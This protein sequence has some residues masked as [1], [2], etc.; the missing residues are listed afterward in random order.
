MTALKYRDAV[1]I[2]T[3]QPLV[4]QTGPT[5]QDDNARPH[6]ARIVT[7]YVQQQGLQTLP[8]PAR[9][10]NL[11]PTEQLWDELGTRTYER[12][13]GIRTRQQLEQVLRQEWQAIPQRTVRNV[14]NSMRSRVN[15]CIDRN[16]GHTKYRVRYVVNNDISCKCR[17]Y[18]L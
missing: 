5:F 3:V 10:P 1:L 7:D 18:K 11:S 8:W 14:I 4:P 2:P 12:H 9:S 17:L 16:G 13:P 15:A 6:R